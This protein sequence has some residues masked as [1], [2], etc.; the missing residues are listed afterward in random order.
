MRKLK[1]LLVLAVL[2]AP[3]LGV[4]W[5]AT[6]PAVLL[7]PA[8][9]LV[10]LAGRWGVVY[11]RA[12]E[13][14]RRSLLM[15]VRVRLGWLRL[16]TM[17]GMTTND[18]TPALPRVAHVVKGK[19]YRFPIAKSRARFPRLRVRADEYGVVIH[20]TTIPK[21]GLAEWQ[22]RADD[23]SNAW[24]SVRVTAEQDKPGTVRIRAVHRDPL[25]ER[26][27]WV[28]S[29][30]EPVEADWTSWLVG[31]DEYA[32]DARL[33]LANVPGMVLAGLPG[34][35]KTSLLGGQL[36]A[37]YA[38]SRKVAFVLVD[39]KGGGDYDL[40]S[41]RAAVYAGDDLEA[42][43][44]VLRRLTTLRQD[45][46]A[47]MSLPVA[48]G[49]LGTR[50]F[51]NAGPS[52]AW[53]WVVVVIDEAHTFLDEIRGSRRGDEAARGA[54]GREPSTPDRPREEVPL[55]RNVRRPGHAEGDRRRD[56][57][58]DP[59]RVPAPRELR[60]NDVGRRRR[61]AG[62]GHSR[63]PASVARRAARPGVRRRHDREDARA[64]RIHPR[65][66]AVRRRGRSGAHRRA[67]SRPEGRP[68]GSRAR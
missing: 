29:G 51:W 53:P 56:P 63:L 21:V 64:T 4:W 1:A 68:V 49:G 42:A 44:E 58:C 66:Y 46:Q 18:P 38:P 31:R 15:S 65:A 28:P 55:G 50:N 52:E 6:H 25:V 23:L 7:V 3:V 59:R 32:G 19:A 61:R 2:S 27:E 40:W 20:A 35:G 57:D 26:T 37:R 14:Q 62:G 12:S 45:R 8:A 30:E 17:L 54:H 34:S 47:A 41:D 5:V 67:D 48:A 43:N 13:S 60:P 33:A 11:A 22:K 36:L 10:V 24:R 9:V 16:A 39:G